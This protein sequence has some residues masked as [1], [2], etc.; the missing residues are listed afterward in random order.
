MRNMPATADDPPSLLLVD[1]DP[2]LCGALA[3]SLTRRGFVVSV[4]HDANEA[5][6]VA[7]AT[8]PEYAVVDLRMPGASGLA[9][10]KMLRKLD[11]ETRIVVLTG[12]ASVTTA[13]E[14][15][16]LGAMNYLAKPTDA[17]EIVRA[18]GRDEGDPGVPVAS[19]PVSVG[20][21]E[22]EH[23]Q[24]VLAENDG[25]VST[26]ARALHMHRRTLQRKLAKK[27]IRR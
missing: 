8:P 11:A 26:T 22:W 13:V 4:A 17:D 24:K 21:L 12:Y 18:L 20:R 16:K 6:A 19:Q 5:T 25:N 7:H 15:I 2:T 23:L 9:V 10:V 3:S 1:D 14:A 27:P